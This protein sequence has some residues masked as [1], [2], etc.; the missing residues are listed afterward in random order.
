M[1]PDLDYIVCCEC[2][3]LEYKDEAMRDGH[4]HWYCAKCWELQQR[5]AKADAM[6][7]QAKE[8]GL[9]R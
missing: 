1:N 4:G 7:D 9:G 3:G 2:L 6:I 8:D 5:V